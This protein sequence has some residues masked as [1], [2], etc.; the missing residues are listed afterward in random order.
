MRSG[1]EV[2]P[3][4]DGNAEPDVP[5]FLSTN[6]SHGAGGVHSSETPHLKCSGVSSLRQHLAGRAG[7][8]GA[9]GEQTIPGPSTE[10]MTASGN[11]FL[12]PHQNL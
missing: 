3:D 6:L 5:I 9:G 1:D 10:R 7:R 12:A 11:L 2:S 4:L 8:D